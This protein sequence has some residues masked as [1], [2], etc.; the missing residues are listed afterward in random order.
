[1]GSRICRTIVLFRLCH[2]MGIYTLVE[3]PAHPSTG[4]LAATA[5]FRELVRD[6]S[7]TSLYR[8]S[9][10]EL[11]HALGTCCTGFCTQVY[12]VA[13]QMQWFGSETAKPTHLFTNHR[14]FAVPWLGE[15]YYLLQW[16]HTA[17]G[18]G[19]AHVRQRACVCVCAHARL[20]APTMVLQHQPIL[21]QGSPWLKKR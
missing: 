8:V 6:L 7:A 4:G 16:S 2:A 13:V 14:C 1:M 17:D 3:Q 9:A 5:R 12:R 18:F 21:Q 19:P 20:W 10:R 15:T 11:V